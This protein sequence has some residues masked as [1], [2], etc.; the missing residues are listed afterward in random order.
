MAGQ[1]K[2]RDLCVV[3]GPDILSHACLNFSKDG[4]APKCSNQRKNVMTHVW[5][6]YHFWKTPGGIGIILLTF[7]FIRV[8]LLFCAQE[9]V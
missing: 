8:F 5:G 3:V 2:N 4:G 1:D 9:L 6:I 7:G